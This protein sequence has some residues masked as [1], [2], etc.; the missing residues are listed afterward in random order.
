MFY[1]PYNWWHSS[2]G[3]RE[4]INEMIGYYYVRLFFRPY[5]QEL[6]AKIK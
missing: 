4:V 2:K 6:K 1:G 5:E 3:F